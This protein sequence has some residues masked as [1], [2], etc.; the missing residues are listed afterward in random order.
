MYDYT[1]Q[2]RPHH[3]PF[4]TD[5]FFLSSFLSSSLAITLADGLPSYP[6]APYFLL[7]LLESYSI[8]SLSEIQA[9]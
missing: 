3:S 5:H 9:Q 4:K 8:K 7:E 6:I 2:Y 1:Q